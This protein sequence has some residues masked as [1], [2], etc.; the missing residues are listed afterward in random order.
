MLRNDLKV[1]QNYSQAKLQFCAAKLFGFL[2][3]ESSNI[4]VILAKLCK[5]SASSLLSCQGV[6]NFLVFLC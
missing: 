1:F 6:F 2:Q 4:A 3:S 5:W